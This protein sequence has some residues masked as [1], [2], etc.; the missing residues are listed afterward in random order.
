MTVQKYIA[1]LTLGPVPQT[2][3]RARL[4]LR[5]SAEKA[6]KLDLAG[7]AE[8][9]ADSFAP[10]RHL[11]V[12][13]F[14]G[15]RGL[16][17]AV[18]AAGPDRIE[19]RLQADPLPRDVIVVALRL[20]IATNDN[21]PGDFQQLLD[22]LDGDR[23]AALAIYAGTD[24]ETEVAGIEITAEGEGP[25]APFDP[26]H[27]G[28]APGLVWQAERLLV[29]GWSTRMP[30]AETEDA[31]LMLS[32][33]RAFLP[34]GTPAEHEPGDE[35]YFPAGGDLAITSISIEAAALRAIL[36]CLGPAPVPEPIEA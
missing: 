8:T 7:D 33:L 16:E 28:G 23:E 35:E 3:R 18:A 11:A 27:L 24:F 20:L 36:A 6:A 26:F 17:V 34:P 15:A 25:A 4:S 21:D 22:A 5:Y 19:V 9:L 1:K 32:A 13:G 14:L 30:D 2:A 29:P 12:R 10:L 31:I